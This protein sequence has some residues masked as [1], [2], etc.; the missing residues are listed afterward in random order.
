MNRAGWRVWLVLGLALSAVYVVVPVTLVTDVVVYNGVGLASVA[1]IV[2]G[3]TR[4]CRR[5]TCS[6][7]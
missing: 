5:P 2:F 6:S 7:S 4:A 1:C 3:L